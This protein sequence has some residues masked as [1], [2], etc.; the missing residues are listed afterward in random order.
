MTTFHAD[1]ARRSVPRYTSYPT[2]DRFSASV[3]ADDQRAALQGIDPGTPVSFYVHV[4]YCH[5]ICWYCGC[6]TGA[7][8]RADRLLDYVG[9][10][11][12][13]IDTVAGLLS[14]QLAAIHF[15]GGTPNALPAATLAGLIDR[16]KSR[17]GRIATVPVSV[18]ID[19]RHCDGAYLEALAD[20]GVT[21][22][23]FGVQTF[24]EAVQRRINRVQP[25]RQVA[26]LVAAARGAG[27]ASINFD[28]LYGLP[29][30]TLEDIEETIALSI[31]LGPDRIAAFGYAHLPRAI[32]RQ[33]MI[34]TESLPDAASRF[35]QSAAIH[36]RLVAAGYW[37][38]GF[39][40]FARPG[41]ILAIAA[42]HGR[43][44]R[45]FQGFTDED[46]DVVI[47]LGASAISQFPDRIVQN[48]KHVGHY[49]SAV[50]GGGLAGAKGAVRDEQ[51]RLRAALIERLLCDGSVDLPARDR[52]GGPWAE[53]L[54][55][56]VDRG[57]ARCDDARLAITPSGRPYARL[58]AACF[59]DARTVRQPAAPALSADIATPA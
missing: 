29:G 9:A 33:R 14:G 28:L 42:R 19:P 39:D 8:G 37:A 52:L 34:D 16:L 22:L 20:A 54:A 46:C 41:D 10:L 56:L 18:E 40:H 51:D 59:D 47:G 30:Q 13:E 48:E 35:A 2:A 26:A 12:A 58:I 57:L 44:R 11:E 1:L 53:Q 38:I 5:E 45:N 15:G 50:L 25:H 31:A 17:F 43:L 55:E 4:P 3:G 49:R 32:P 27:I 21:R 24:A 7:I 6:N 23:S 36:E